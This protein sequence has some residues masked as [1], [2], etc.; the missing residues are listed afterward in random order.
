MR[1]LVV[2]GVLGVARL[3][4][5]SPDAQTPF[6]ALKRLAGRWQARAD[7]THPPIEMTYDVGSKGSIVTEQFGKELSVFHRDG[8]RLSM[9]HFCNAGNQPRLVL[10]ESGPQRLAFEAISTTNLTAP[11]A[12]HVQRIS[13]AFADATH[14][15]LEIVWAQGEK[16]EDGHGDDEHR[17]QGDAAVRRRRRQRCAAAQRARRAQ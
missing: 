10:V 14:F 13:Y 8:D 11:D 2:A 15:T 17:P 7:T 16:R 1:I 9:I 3:A 4:A 5:A 6:E 12:A